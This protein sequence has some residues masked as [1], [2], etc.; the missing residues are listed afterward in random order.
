MRNEAANKQRGWRGFTEITENTRVH[1]KRRKR[2][3]IRGKQ[4]GKT[5]PD[6]EIELR[7]EAGNTTK[8][9]TNTSNKIREQST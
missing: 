3:E 5:K 4:H 2:N 8:N 1:E 6:M 9:N 7:G